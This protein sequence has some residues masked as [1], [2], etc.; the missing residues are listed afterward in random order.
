MPAWASRVLHGDATTNG[1]LQ[2][3]RGVGALGGALFLA[4]LGQRAARGRLLTRATFLMPV[5]VLVFSFIRWLPASLVA[6]AV[7]GVGLI[8]ALNATNSLLQT[9]VPD[10]LRG[11][12]MS[13]YTLAFFGFL[14]LGALLIGALA[15]W[16]G[17]PA[18]VAF[19]AGITLAF[20]V[21]A[22]VLFG[23]IRRIE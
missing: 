16:W 4:W 13:V 23:R 11:R 21:L 10:A 15:D 7:V 3:A 20:A 18:A 17:E 12:V 5:A 14:P 2:S 6:L 22:R 9:L 19:N 8:V 1:F